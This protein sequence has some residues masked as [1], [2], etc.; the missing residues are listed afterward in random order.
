MGADWHCVGPEACFALQVIRVLCLL[1]TPLAVL[2]IGLLGLLA[3]IRD[4]IRKR[5]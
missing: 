5:E 4:L 3:L 2:A 1:L